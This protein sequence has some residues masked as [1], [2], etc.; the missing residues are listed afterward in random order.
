M[1]TAIVGVRI[2]HIDCELTASLTEKHML[3]GFAELVVIGM[4]L[5]P[6]ISIILTLRFLINYNKK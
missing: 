4:L 5:I 2:T 1:N 6:I 3:T